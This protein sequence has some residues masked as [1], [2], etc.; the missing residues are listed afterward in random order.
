MSLGCW[1][2]S[3]NQYENFTSSTKTLILSYDD[4]GPQILAYEFLGFQWWQ[5]DNHGDSDPRTKYDIRVAI[6]KDVSLEIVKNKYPVN[7]NNK[8][9]FRYVT[10]DECLEYLDKIMT[11]FNDDFDVGRYSDLREKIVFHFKQKE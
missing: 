4:F 11:E 2:Q 8:L 5:W 3:K 7:R 1:E 9:D 6:Y 10:Y